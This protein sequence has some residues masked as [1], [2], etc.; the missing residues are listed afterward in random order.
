[1]QFFKQSHLTKF[2]FWNQVKKQIM[3]TFL[4]LTILPIVVIGTISTLH[5]RR[6][7]IDQHESQI[8]AEVTRIKSTLFDITTSMYTSCETLLS[9]D[10]N[11]KLF[12]ATSFHRAEEQQYR[13]LTQTLN[14]MH[15]STAAIS[16]IKVYTNNPNIPS[17]TYI[18][19]CANGFVGYDWYSKIDPVSTDWCNWSSIEDAMGDQKNKE[20]HELTMSRRFALPSS[21]SAYLVVSISDNYLKNRLL[22]TDSFILASIN[23]SP[24]FFSSDRKWIHSQFPLPDPFNNQYQ[25]YLGK[26]DLNDHSYFANISTFV[27]YRANVKFY[28]LVG[29]KDTYSELTQRTLSY[30]AIFSIAGLLPAILMLIFSKSLSSRILDL[31]QAMHQASLGDYN[32]IHSFRGN[33]ELSEI[34]TDLQTTVDSIREKELRYYEEKIARQQMINRQQQ[35]EFKMLASQINPHF[36][37]NTL[38]MIR[39]QALANEDPDVANSI[40]LLGRSMHYVLEN[41]GTNATTLDKE[42]QYIETYLS[43]QKLRFG[44]RVNYEIICDPDLSLDHY[45]ILPLLLQPIVENAVS[46]GL[47]GIKINGLITIQLKLLEEGLVKITIS[48]NGVGMS[49]EDLCALRDRIENGEGFASSSIG[50]YNINQR[51]RLLYG[52]E[53]CLQIDSELGTGTSVTLLLPS[54]CIY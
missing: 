23:D 45:K 46:H 7:L 50:L 19:S 9:S 2:K 30:L 25:S 16:S 43:I 48:D 41:T 4:M 5:M 22:Y 44:A 47:E 17:N 8:S 18:T 42:L 33:D 24:V 1:M 29:N 28:I 14:S 11:Q 36:L 49:H 26:V 3:I 51:I 39:M 13:G 10:S 38:E 40:K 12:S 21:Y 32:I 27:P 34:F 35:M 31:R 20:R 53:Y 54:N 15:A 52:K 6:Q 37:Y